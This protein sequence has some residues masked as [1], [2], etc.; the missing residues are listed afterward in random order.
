[1]TSARTASGAALGVDEIHTKR[2]SDRVTVGRVIAAF[3]IYELAFWLAYRYGMSFSQLTASPFWFPDSVLLCALLLTPRRWWWAFVLGALPLRLFLPEASGTP[4]WFLWSAL[5][6]DSAKGIVTAWALRRFLA[7]PLK[8]RTV[9]DFVL[10]G[11]MENRSRPAGW[12]G[13]FH[14]FT[15]PRPLTSARISTRP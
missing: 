1:M 10:Y 12:I 5:V 7:D 9:Q 14:S 3:V 4:S 15:E 2:P 11:L 13:R 8:L 6:I